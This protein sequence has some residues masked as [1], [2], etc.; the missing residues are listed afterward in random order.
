MGLQAAI[1]AGRRIVQVKKALRFAIVI[2]VGESE[3][4]K[5]GSTG[6]GASTYSKYRD[7]T[8]SQLIRLYSLKRPEAKTY[9]Y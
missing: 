6:D 1:A 9:S 2:E 5:I 7:G 3:S 4:A 8:L